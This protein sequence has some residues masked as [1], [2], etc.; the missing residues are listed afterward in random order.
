MHA[1]V[2]RCIPPP[3]RL[4]MF[5]IKG[6]QHVGAAIT[7]LAAP[8]HWQHS[9]WLPLAPHVLPVHVLAFLILYSIPL[10]PDDTAIVLSFICSSLFYVPINFGPSLFKAL[11]LLHWP[12]QYR[13]IYTCFLGRKW[14]LE[15]W[16]L[17]YEIRIK[18]G[19]LGFILTKKSTL[20]WHS[21]YHYSSKT[22]DLAPVTLTSHA[23]TLRGTKLVNDWMPYDLVAFQHT[24]I[25]FLLPREGFF[26]PFLMIAFLYWEQMRCT[27]LINLKVYH[28]GKLKLA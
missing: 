11:C 21:E 17:D 15:V 16:T 9:Y 12:G 28:I 22:Q 23:Y 13:C 3:S 6:R 4:F 26:S 7:T 8:P 10:L 24:F 1:S 19:P 27:E 14:Q 2:I 18:R 25:S 20:C 5:S